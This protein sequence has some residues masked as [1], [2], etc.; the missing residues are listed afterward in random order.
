MK[1]YYC[2]NC[3]IM[4]V[5]DMF[6]EVCCK[7]GHKKKGNEIMGIEHSDVDILIENSVIYKMLFG[8]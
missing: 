8:E 1:I 5:E 7:C 3:N 2:D 6:E 4:I